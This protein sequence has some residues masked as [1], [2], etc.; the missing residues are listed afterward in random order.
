MNTAQTDNRITYYQQGPIDPD[1]SVKVNVIWE[2]KLKLPQSESS[3]LTP[4]L[5]NLSALEEFWLEAIWPSRTFSVW[6]PPSPIQEQMPISYHKLTFLPAS[7][8]AWLECWYWLWLWSSEPNGAC[9]LTIIHIDKYMVRWLKIMQD[10]WATTSK[11]TWPVLLES[12]ENS[13][14]VSIAQCTVSQKVKCRAIFIFNSSTEHSRI[15][16]HTGIYLSN[17]L[18]LIDTRTSFLRNKLLTCSLPHSILISG[19]NK[20]GYWERQKSMSVSLDT[21]QAYH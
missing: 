4:A 8:M 10:G 12:L 18:V 1:G 17:V 21:D 9:A 20:S 11:Y 15:M 16:Q 13:T 14:K 7:K 3:T 19:I 2:F 6:F 5:H